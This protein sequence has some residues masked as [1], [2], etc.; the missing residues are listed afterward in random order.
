M[1][2]TPDA[3][4][5]AQHHDQAHAKPRD[6]GATMTTSTQAG[7]IERYT[8]DVW[9]KGDLDAIAEL[10]TADR[11]RHGPDFEGTSVGA[12]GHRELVA[13]YRTCLPDLVIVAEAQVQDGDVVVTRWRATGTNLGPTLGVPPTGRRVE[14]FG[15]WMH[16]FDGDR[17][18]E[19]WAVWDTHGF[20]QQI[21][22]TLPG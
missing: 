4:A 21:G 2:R 14:V 13:L 15:L 10:F 18:A 12:A 19:E 6:E 7:A 3:D 8:T 1:G 5:P 22:I 17:I 16:R 9:S 11:V 20:L